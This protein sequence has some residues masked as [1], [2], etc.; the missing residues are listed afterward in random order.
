MEFY[1]LL[2]GLYLLSGVI[3]TV[4]LRA[5]ARRK[6]GRE[7]DDVKSIALILLWPAVML[8]LA[9]A[10]IGGFLLWLVLLVEKAFGKSP[11]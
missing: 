7:P 6:N 10:T 2:A 11:K 1:S 8:V 4:L 3:L 9:V 5:L